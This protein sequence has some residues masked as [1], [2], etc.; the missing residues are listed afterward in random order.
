MF[1]SELLKI[2]NVLIILALVS[3]WLWITKKFSVLHLN[4][5]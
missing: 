4:D 3:V 5:A 1:N 2:E